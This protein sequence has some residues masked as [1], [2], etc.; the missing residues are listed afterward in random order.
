MDTA[1]QAIVGLVQGGTLPMMRLKEWQ[2]PP[3]T[4]GAV[5]RSERAPRQEGE[6]AHWWLVSPVMDS[7]RLSPHHTVTEHEDGTITV[8]PSVCFD[9]PGKSGFHGF[10]KAGVWEWWTF[11]D[12]R[13]FQDGSLAPLAPGREEA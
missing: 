6:V 3:V 10:L 13:Y 9:G 8:D 1:G 4:H 7:G 12:L 11:S 2:D 5:Y